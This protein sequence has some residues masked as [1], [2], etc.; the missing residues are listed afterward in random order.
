M[1]AK[2]MMSFEEKVLQAYPEKIDEITEYL[3]QDEGIKIF[4]NSPSKEEI[5]A[6]LNE[7]S[8]R[9]FP[10]YNYGIISYLNHELDNIHIIDIE[11]D[12]VLER[13]TEVSIDG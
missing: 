6:K 2:L 1:E 13:F 11:F 12:G 3:S 9:V 7:P 8:I 5:A 4:F 10:E